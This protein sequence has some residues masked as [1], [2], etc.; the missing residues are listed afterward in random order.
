MLGN[1]IL[2]GDILCP[3]TPQKNDAGLTRLC[4]S[5]GY[6]TFCSDSRARYIEYLF[7]TCIYTIKILITLTLLDSIQ[8]TV[9]KPN[10]SL[11]E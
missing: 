2:D 9:K 11:M 3:L 4:Q 1:G 7:I 5:A 10:Q 6:G 8:H